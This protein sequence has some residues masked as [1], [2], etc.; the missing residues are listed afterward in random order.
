MKI[1]IPPTIIDP[2]E[3]AAWTIQNW[4]IKFV[5]SDRVLGV[6]RKQSKLDNWYEDPAVTD[7]WIERMD[8]CAYSI[9]KF[10]TAFGALPHVGDRL[11]DKTTIG[12]T[13]EE[14]SIDGY[15]MTITFTLST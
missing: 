8:I 4:K 11:F 3:H 14:R 7:A 9:K 6:V 2:I 10:H 12:A 1:K 5:L 15:L 13:I